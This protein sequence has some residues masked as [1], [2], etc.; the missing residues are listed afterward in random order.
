M[1]NKHCPPSPIR[2]PA[3]CSEFSAFMSA[4]GSSRISADLFCRTWRR[5]Q[6]A[7]HTLLPYSNA[8]CAPER[9]ASG[10]SLP[11]SSAIK[12]PPFSHHIAVRTP[13]VAAAGV[14]CWPTLY[15]IPPFCVHCARLSVRCLIKRLC[16]SMSAYSSRCNTS[17][18]WITFKLIVVRSPDLVGRD[19][20]RCSAPYTDDGLSY[21]S[22]S[23]SFQHI[24][25]TAES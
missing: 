16:R 13:W 14:S 25:N 20:T 6:P 22:T 8:F 2:A 21:K 11:R 9:F 18:S 12:L 23:L 3:N 15:V 5:R 7:G 4:L 17:L 10:V 24:S 1:I 19:E